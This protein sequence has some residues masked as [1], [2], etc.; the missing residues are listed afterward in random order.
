MD[1]AVLF[2]H[3][4]KL[5][6]N[7]KDKYLDF[8]MWKKNKKLWNIKVTVI[9]IVTGTL[10]TVTKGLIKGQEDMEIRGGVDTIQITALLRSVRREE[11]CRHEETCFH[12]N[13]SG[14]LSANTGVKNSQDNDNNFRNKSNPLE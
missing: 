2:D 7:E 8:A 4:V 12:S 13:S 6:E 11:S 5:K 9:P 14:K 3:K 10:G 1:F